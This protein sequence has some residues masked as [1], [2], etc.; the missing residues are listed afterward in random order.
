MT[1]RRRA[2]ADLDHDIRGHLERETQ[3]NVERGMSPAD[4]RA[5]ALRKF[6][7]VGLIRGE[8]RAVWRH[9]WIDQLWHDLLF[10]FRILRR[11]PGFTAVA[12]LTL[13]VG[14]GLNTA[15]FSVVNSVL[16]RPLEY[17]HPER[18]VWL[19]ETTPPSTATWSCSPTRRPGVS[20]ARSYD[21]VASY[22]FQQAAIATSRTAFPIAAV[23]AGGDFSSLT[24]T[25]SAL[26]RLFSPGERNGVVI[27]WDLFQRQFG[28]DPHAVGSAVTVDGSASTITGVLPRNF[29]FQFPRWWTALHPE[30]DRGLPHAS[31]GR[32][33]ASRRPGG[34]F[35][36]TRRLCLASVRR[37]RVSAAQPA[38]AG[39]VA[40]TVERHAPRRPSPTTN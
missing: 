23:L 24:G 2:L 9:P 10:A 20:R 26:G 31:T 4:A 28:G 3:E 13:A 11:A 36:Q 17:P 18:L 39:C 7:N 37:A 6:G 15:V 8:T 12:V 14:I 25:T 35:A 21:G 19:G 16:L 38:S 33:T 29:R 34:G 1:R 22:S 40:D 30:P 32:G 27:S 5:A